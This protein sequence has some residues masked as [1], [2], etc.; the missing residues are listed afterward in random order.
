MNIQ[1]SKQFISI[2]ALMLYLAVALFAQ[3]ATISVT[4]ETQW[5]RNAIDNAHMNAR[6]TDAADQY[7]QYAPIPR[8]AFYDIGFPKDKAEFESLNGYGILLVCALSQ[9]GDELPIK[10]A[11]VVSEGKQVDL[12][13]LKEIFVKNP[14]LKSQTV[15]TFGQ[16]RVDSLYLFPVPYQRAVPQPRRSVFGGA[17]SVS[18]GRGHAL[19]QP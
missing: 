9:D 2:L 18:A 17:S 16:Y 15:G 11:Y 12:I 7:K 10:R 3:D 1:R 4:S 8:I 13:K 6:I 5:H 19:L 14:D